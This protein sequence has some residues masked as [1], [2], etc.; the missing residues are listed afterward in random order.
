MGKKK[1]TLIIACGALAKELTWVIKA[2]QWE[3]FVEVTCLPA[4]LHNRPENIPERM[5][6]KISKNRNNFDQIIALY[7]DCGTGGKL[8]Q[9]LDEENVVRIPGAH[10]YEFYTGHSEF[11]NIAQEELGTFYLTDYLV[12]FFDKLILDGLGI[13]KYPQLLPV[14]FGN[15]K[16]LVYL[17]QSPDKSLRKKAERAASKLGLAFEYKLTGFHGI[18]NFLKQNI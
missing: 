14:Y 8:D 12:R 16:R 11:S 5:R 9:V 6:K 7:G 13:K 2:N 18:S 10:C 15:Y 4:K 17:A 1:Q 3:S